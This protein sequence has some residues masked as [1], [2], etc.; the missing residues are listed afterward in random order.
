MALVRTL[1]HL[2]AERGLD[3]RADVP[4]S[5]VVRVQRED[6]DEMLGN[7]LDNA[8]KWAARAV[9]AEAR[10]EGASVT[11]AEL[12]EHCRERLA[13]Y[14]VPKDVTFIDALPRNPSGK[15]LKRELRTRVDG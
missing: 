12:V 6:L 4:D 11:A 1:E 7:L 13:R 3:L 5:A 2:H 9:H 8:C 14:K 10:R 15:V